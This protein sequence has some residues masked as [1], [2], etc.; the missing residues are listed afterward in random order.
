MPGSCAASAGQEVVG[1]PPSRTRVGYRDAQ[2]P[3][4]AAGIAAGSRAASKT[5]HFKQRTGVPGASLSPHV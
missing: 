1:V 3:M 2:A 5:S 4:T